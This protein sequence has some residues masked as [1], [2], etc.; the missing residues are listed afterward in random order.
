MRG[1]NLALLVL[2]FAML[3]LP[4]G[5]HDFLVVHWMKIGTFMAPFLL[6]VVFALKQDTMSKSDPQLLSLLMLV[7]YIAHQFEEHWID[8]TGEAYAFSPY[9]NALLQ[10]ASGAPETTVILSPL[11]I[12]VINTSLVWL[13]G[14]IA[15]LLSPHRFFPYL[16]MAAIILVNA[17][18]HILA[19]ILT[20]SYNPGV[21]TSL[22]VFLPMA[23]CAFC[24][25]PQASP[26][27]KFASIAWAV[28]AHIVMIGGA[29]GA[30]RFELFPELVYFAMLVAISIAP[31][32]LFPAIKPREQEDPA[33]LA[34]AD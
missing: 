16:C 19:A 30:N 23:W 26:G 5:Q 13:V 33:R 9:V 14:F 27:V 31:A 4:L 2:G 20:F 21:A 12:L 28:F 24:S 18:S 10:S 17:V 34:H 7:A 11:A 8:L 25:V 1:P 6:F 15:V 32:F 22:L 3:W 29:L